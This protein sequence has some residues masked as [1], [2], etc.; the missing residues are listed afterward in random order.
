MCVFSVL[1]R[2]LCLCSIK[3]GRAEGRGQREKRRRTF[4]SLCQQ[5]K[6][7]GLFVLPLLLFLPFFSPFPLLFDPVFLS[8]AGL[9]VLSLLPYL[10]LLP[11]LSLSALCAL[12]AS[13]PACRIHL[14]ASDWLLVCV[15]AFS[16]S[17]A[18]LWRSPNIHKS[19]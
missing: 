15:G 4:G 8:P 5:T 11:F 10:H 2:H 6:P 7:A 17:S 12:I 18:S 9:P 16:L 1:N 19:I 13:P 3:G 14:P